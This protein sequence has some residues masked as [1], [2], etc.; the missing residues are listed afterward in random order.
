MAELA[1]QAGVDVEVHQEGVRRY[2]AEITY[3]YFVAEYR[4]GTYIRQFKREV[5]ADEFVRQVRDRRVQLHYKDSAPDVSVILE[6]DLD[7]IAMVAP[8]LS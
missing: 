1:E 8:Q 7:L 3:S 2:W 5:D 4:S 6:R